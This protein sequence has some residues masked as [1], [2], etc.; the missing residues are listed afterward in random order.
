MHANAEKHKSKLKDQDIVRENLKSNG[1][2]LKYVMI[3]TVQLLIIIVI[4][5]ITINTENM[6]TMDNMA[7][8]LKEII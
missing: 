3:S 5:N 6:V 4:T 2:N 8:M 7:I 1:S